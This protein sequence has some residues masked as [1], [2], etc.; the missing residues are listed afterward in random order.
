MTPHKRFQVGTFLLLLLL[1]FALVFAVVQPFLNI[2]VLAFILAIIFRPLYHRFNKKFHSEGWSALATVGVI[3]V[4]ILVPLYLFGQL[5]FNELVDVYQNLRAGNLVLNQERLFG[6]LPDQVRQAIENISFDLNNLASRITQNAFQTFS[7]VVSNIASFILSFFLVMFATYYF[8]KDGHK[9]RQVVVDLS[10]IN[11]AQE[12]ILFGKVASAING[13][14]K[15][16]FLI[17][18]LQGIIATIGFFIFGVPNALLWGMFTVAMALVPS[19]GTALAIGPAVLY[20]LV[21]GNIGSAIGLTIWGATAVG[22]VDNFLGPKLI[23]TAVKVHPLLVLISVLGGI[24]F[25]GFIGFLLGPILMAVFVAMV[26][27][28]RTDF[29]AYLEK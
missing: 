22:L 11:N 20:L 14:V 27:M 28:Y 19:V 16:T 13:V 21:T 25:F 29:Q 15:G 10:P 24:S 6:V 1:T 23:G 9:I 3:L 7:Q 17:A 26:D 5:L 8:L 4:I 2:I 18:L 12:N